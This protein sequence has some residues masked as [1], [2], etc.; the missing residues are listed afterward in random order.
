VIGC[1]APPPATVRG[2]EQLLAELESSRLEVFLVPSRR[3]VNEGGCVRVAVSKNAGWYRAFCRRHP[4]G[5]L[6]R[7]AAPD[8]RIKRANVLRLLAQLAEGKP[9]TSKYAPEI[10]RI[11]RQ[12]LAA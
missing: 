4:S 2:L 1:A 3:R 10:L 8:T 7:N 11:A 6:R 12:A 5:R 9:S